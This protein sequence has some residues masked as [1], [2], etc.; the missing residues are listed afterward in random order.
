V[1]YRKCSSLSSLH[2]LHVVLV[3]ATF[4]PPLHVF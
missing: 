2:L 1:C 3:G 4:A